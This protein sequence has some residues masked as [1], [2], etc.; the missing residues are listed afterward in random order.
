[1]RSKNG[2]EFVFY[3]QPE[4]IIK[5]F[6]TIGVYGDNVDSIELTAG[7]ILFGYYIPETIISSSRETVLLRIKSGYK[8][9][10]LEMNEKEIHDSDHYVILFNVKEMKFIKDPENILDYL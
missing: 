6:N 8:K 3:K 9:S 7:K 10:Y 1:M 5:W 2:W 4:N